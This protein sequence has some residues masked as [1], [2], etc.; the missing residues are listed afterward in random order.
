MDRQREE[1]R[2][3]KTIGISA[4]RYRTLAYG[5]VE[6]LVNKKLAQESESREV[7]RWG[8]EPQQPPS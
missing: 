6:L 7:G 2:L 8:F 1:T 3:R 4:A 5:N